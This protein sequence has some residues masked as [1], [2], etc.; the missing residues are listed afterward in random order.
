MLGA[1]NLI[2]PNLRRIL[3]ERD[4]KQAEAARR[5]GIETRSF[6]QYAHGDRKVP[7]HVVP[8]LC[9]G[10]GVTPNDL[11]G[12][13]IPLGDAYV[14]LLPD[15]PPTTARLPHG[16][17]AVRVLDTRAGLGGGG[18]LIE[19][20]EGEVRLFDEHLVLHELK[21]TPLDLLTLE[22]EGQSME[23]VLCSG[24]RVLIDRR[25][26]NVAE[27]GLFV[28]W[29]GDGLVCKWVER[30]H[31]RDE[32]SLRIISENTRFAAYSRLIEECRIIG[33]VVW[34]ARPL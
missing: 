2:A 3:N 18:V 7:E 15:Q 13:S 26:T 4:L 32:P 34:F 5:C 9:N 14:G 8:K 28:L 27:P 11:F 10:L 12:V 31:E 23:P 16:Q 30:D 22:V 20:A 29:D 33:R 25:K 21:A 24:D 6:G 1:M 17:V 19:N